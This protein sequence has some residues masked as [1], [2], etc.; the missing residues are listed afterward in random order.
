M[1]FRTS[2]SMFAN[3]MGSPLSTS[4]TSNLFI[5]SRMMVRG[6]QEE[7]QGHITA[8]LPCFNRLPLYMDEHFLLNR[9]KSL[10][11]YCNP[12]GHNTFPPLTP[13]IGLSGFHKEF[14]HLPIRAAPLASPSSTKTT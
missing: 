4:S 3:D 9:K 2:P 5:I 1:R 10:F 12:P 11:S 6:S 7:K 13:P 8:H 14:I